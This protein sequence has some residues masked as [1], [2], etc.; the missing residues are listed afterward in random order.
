V[1]GGFKAPIRPLEPFHRYLEPTGDNEISSANVVQVLVHYGAIP[2][3]TERALLP[4][5]CRA[6]HRTDRNF[7][8]MKKHAAAGEEHC[9]VCDHRVILRGY[10]D[11]ATTN[12]RLARE[13]D[14]TANAPKTSSDV[15]AGSPTRYWWKCLAVDS[16]RFE[17]TAS[18]RSAAHSA[19]P[20]CLGRLVI[21]T[22]NDAESLFPH[23]ALEF[24]PTK[25]G[26]FQLSE[27]PAN[28]TKLIWWTCPASHTYRATVGKRTRG[29]GCH[30]C[31]RKATSARTIARSHP[32]LVTEWDIAR[33]FPRT[34]DEVTIG[35]MKQF[36]W[37]CP[38]GHS[39]QQRPERRAAGYGCPAC[40]HRKLVRG[41]N[42]AE[43][44]H[45]EICGEW[46]PY[47]NM[48]RPSE[49]MPGTKTYFWACEPGKH[50]TQQ[51][52]PHRVLSGGCTACAPEHRARAGIVPTDGF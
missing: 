28:S 19:C 48:T 14:E 51:S 50:L 5:I 34:T 23:L 31:V 18:N 15:F 45:P 12:P 8:Q 36:H 46:H 52:I 35:S 26:R 6:G 16:H 47:L 24:H 43:T 9:G 42:D 33:N 40:S 29:E 32:K 37:V 11:M 27:L 38:A 1:V 39:Y 41:V 30:H 21:S 20:L 22:V 17:A 13:F 10:N 44:L 3:V 7:T 4:T 49:I 2:A 25:N